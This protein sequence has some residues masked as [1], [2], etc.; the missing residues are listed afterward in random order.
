MP[1]LAQA[2]C[3][4]VTVALIETLG[5]VGVPPFIYFRF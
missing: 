5:P 3:I 1:T 4:G 2:G